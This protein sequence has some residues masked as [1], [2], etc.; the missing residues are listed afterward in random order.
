ML[1][2]VCYTNYTWHVYILNISIVCIYE[3]IAT[4]T[5][6]MRGGAIYKMKDIAILYH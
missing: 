5:I 1:T 6:Q 4:R 2:A 3:N